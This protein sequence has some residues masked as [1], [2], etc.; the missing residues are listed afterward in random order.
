MNFASDEQR[1]NELSEDHKRLL[2]R[3]W[4]IKGSTLKEFGRFY[5]YEEIKNFLVRLPIDK[6]IFPY[7]L[8]HRWESTPSTRCTAD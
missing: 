7:F 1:F 6:G 5:P 2:R 3:L 4:V 8:S